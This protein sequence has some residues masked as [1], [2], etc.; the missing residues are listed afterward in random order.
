MAEMR[1]EHFEVVK[2]DLKAIP[3]SLGPI[4]N[5]PGADFR[6]WRDVNFPF[7]LTYQSFP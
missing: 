5:P 4:L 7:S 2:C 3:G 1:D 6:L